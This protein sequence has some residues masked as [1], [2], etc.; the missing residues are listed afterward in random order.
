MCVHRPLS[1]CLFFRLFSPDRAH[2]CAFMLG[3]YIFVLARLLY[4]G[5]QKRKGEW[6]D[7]ISGWRWRIAGLTEV[8]GDSEWSD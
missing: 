5:Q 2:V 4:N 8:N 6:C 7:F 1:I 3:S